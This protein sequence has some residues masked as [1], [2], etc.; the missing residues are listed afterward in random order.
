MSSRREFLAGAV[1]GL[2]S[3]WLYLHGPSI[4]S[5]QAHA[6]RAAQSG[7]AVFEFLSKEQATEVEAVA[8]QILPS[9]DTCGAREAGVIHFIDRALTSFDR[10]R[11]E[12][13]RQG[14]AALQTKVRSLFPGHDRFSELPA[15]QQIQ[16]LTAIENT[17]FFQLV[18]LHTIMGFLAKPEY[19][20][21]NNQVGWKLIGFADQMQNK[22]PFGYYDR[23]FSKDG[24]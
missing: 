14:V 17:E 1:S 20:G 16:L 4:M 5:A 22:P 7:L 18:R 12:T 24:Q 13:Y 9:K 21:N 15:Q 11:Q 19:G 10:E 2:S 23:E 3:A 8:A 6:R